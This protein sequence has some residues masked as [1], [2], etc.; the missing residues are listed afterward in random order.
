MASLLIWYFTM[1]V[2]GLAAYPIAFVM[3]KNL[4][5]KGYVFSKVLA[6]LLVGYFSWILG[7]VSFG[8]GTIFISFLLL[9]GLSTLL[10]LTWIGQSFKEFFKKN[11]G[12]FLLMEALFLMAFL[13]AGAF[14]MRT[15]DIVNQEKPMD[16]SFINGIL[17]SP[18][19]PPQDPWLSGGSISYYYF[20]YLIV[21]VLCKITQ[22]TSGEA[23]NLMIALTWALA[24]LCAFSVGYAI[25]R[26]YRYSIFSAL[27]LAVFGNLDYWHRALQSFQ[28]GDLRIPYY[29]FPPS[30]GVPTGLSAFWGFLFSPLQHYWDYFQASRVIPVTPT[31]KMITEFPSFSFFLSDLHPH[32]MGIP[33]VLLAIAISLNT[34][35]ST[36][37][38]LQIFSGSVPWRWTQLFLVA[39]AFGGL[40]FMNVADFTTFLGLFI[41]CLLFQQWWANENNFE[42]WVKSVVSVAVPLV[43]LAVI[44]YL[45]FYLRYQSQVQGIGLV[46]DRN[47]FYYLLVIF[48]LFFAVLVPAL[49]GKALKSNQEKG[50]RPKGKRPEI[51]ACAICGKEGS[52]KKFCGFC[53]GELVSF[54]SEVVPLPNETVRPVLVKA[55][56]FLSAPQNG[57]IALG[58]S[59]AVLLILNLIPAKLGIAF[60]AFLFM[61]ICLLC[62]ASA[63]ENREVVFSILLAFT[64]FLLI[65]GCELVYVRDLFSGALYRMNTVFKYYYHVWILFSVAMAPWLKWLVE[66]LWPRWVAWRKG[67]WAALAAFA[68]FGAALYPALAFS[69]RIQGTS[70]DMATMDGSLYYERN[71]PD[72]YEAAQWIEQNVKPVGGK[73]PVILEAFGGSYAVSVDKS[74]GRLAMMTGYP[75][76]LGWDFHEV[77]WHGTWNGPVIRGGDPNDTIQNRQA[78]VDAIYTSP[79]MNQ[80]WTLLKKYGVDYVYVGDAER[81][82]YKD[83]LESLGKFGQLG[84]II[85]TFGNSVLYKINQQ[86]QP[87]STPLP[88]LGS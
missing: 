42:A 50:A 72:N 14:K 39:L 20:G 16:F 28:F 75:T 17:A 68:L 41:L 38:G 43:A 77:Q 80:T 66:N 58:A 23:F 26:R 10:L 33:L 69:A 30:P 74:G 67:L 4:P 56:T 9:A 78:D 64:G 27:C 81:A 2:M 88:G 79:D 19:M 44:L 46:T 18:S 13:V 32:V 25:T 73:I 55:S 82:K 70:P 84:T 37:P 47:D 61:A 11:V 36:L 85:Q 8:G 35:Q 48:G 71:T 31:D 15:P 5:D 53:G 52:G 12:F 57:W 63:W 86:A 62:L 65:W 49:V 3:L 87:H 45:P 22:V 34:L 60:F 7:Y 54:P 76:V 29:N 83:H 1:L 59:L 21:A 51:L 24:T 40:D 6:L